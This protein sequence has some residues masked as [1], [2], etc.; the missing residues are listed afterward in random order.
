MAGRGKRGGYL[1][2]ME[3]AKRR[4]LEEDSKVKVGEVAEKKREEKEEHKSSSDERFQ[5]MLAKATPNDIYGEYL[6]FLKMLPKLQNNAE[7]ELIKTVR[8]NLKIDEVKLEL[9]K[10]SS[11]ERLNLKGDQYPLL[12]A[13]SFK[14]GLCLRNILA[15]PTDTCLLCEKPLQRNNKPTVVPFHTLGGPEMASKYS[16]ECRSCTGIYSFRGRYENN[17]R[18]YYSVDQYGNPD[19]GFKRY[20][21]SFEVSAFRIEMERLFWKQM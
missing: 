3:E 21:A 20:P 9:S 16:W 11:G 12:D 4:K 7:Q 17:C 14:L 5:T 8:T 6:F 19:M 10:P 13:L 15:P 1:A 2:Q 18:V